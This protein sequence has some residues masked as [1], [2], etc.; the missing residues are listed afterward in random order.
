VEELR[1]AERDASRAEGVALALAQ[2]R[3]ELR[4]SVT[5]DAAEAARGAAGLI[6]CTPV[7]MVGHEGT[8]LPRAAMAGAEWAFDAVYTPVE[9]QFL[10]DAAAEGL[11]VISG[12]ELFFHQGVDA[13]ALFSGTPVDP[14]ALRA[15]L[16]AEEG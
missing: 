13:W 7:G 6:N 12:Y 15:A 14:G 9:T 3:P 2:A 8:P 4:V 11:R 10:K 5:G 1:I 16:A